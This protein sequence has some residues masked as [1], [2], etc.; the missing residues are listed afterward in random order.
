MRMHLPWT[1]SHLVESRA[2]GFW[3]PVGL[4]KFS[5]LPWERGQT[6]PHLLN[7]PSAT[8]ASTVIWQSS[9]EPCLPCPALSTASTAIEFRLNLP[10]T[11]PRALLNGDASRFLLLSA[12]QSDPGKR[13]VSSCCVQLSNL[14]LTLS[15][16]SILFSEE[17]RKKAESQVPVLWRVT[18]L[19]DLLSLTQKGRQSIPFPFFLPS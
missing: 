17:Q 19:E 11:L 1:H 6:I 10:R 8:R 4:Q 3:A 13:P 7:K 5:A 15:L 12:A 14:Q 18:L 9:F 2:L 16:L